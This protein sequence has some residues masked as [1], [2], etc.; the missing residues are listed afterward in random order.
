MTWQRFVIGW[1][2]VACIAGGCAFQPNESTERMVQE[3][4]GRGGTPAFS[5]N[6]KGRARDYYGC[7]ERLP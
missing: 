2:V 5:F 4:I 3:C 7:T 6:S 1:V